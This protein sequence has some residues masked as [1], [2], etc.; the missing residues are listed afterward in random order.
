MQRLIS[1]DFH[2]LQI[3]IKQKGGVY[4]PPFLFNEFN[5]KLIST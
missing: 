3:Q 4:T 1:A 2:N 5:F